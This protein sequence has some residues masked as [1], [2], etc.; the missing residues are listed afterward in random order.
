MFEI[1]RKIII[2]IHL[3]YTK[4]T[5]NKHKTNI[6]TNTKQTLTAFKIAHIISPKIDINKANPKIPASK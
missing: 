5:Q 1:F 6:N 3:I 4:Q 2:I